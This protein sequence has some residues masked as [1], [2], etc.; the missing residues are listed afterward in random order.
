MEVTEGHEHGRRDIGGALLLVVRGDLTTQ[1]VDAVVN[2]ANPQLQH[3]GGVAHALSL[4]GGPDVQRLSDEW[5]E[6]HG[7]LSPGA[8]AVTGAGN[9]PAEHVIHVV[10]PRYADGQDNEA[11]LGQ[12]VDAALESAEELGASSIA[13]PVISA[14]TYGYPLQEAAAVITR[15]VAR[16]LAQHPEGAVREVRLVGFDDEAAEAFAAALATD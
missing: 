10:G 7:P 14:G 16:W 5:V 9:L 12:A 4:A 1:G 11:L 2:A 13:L 6:R 15:R 8:A 3:G